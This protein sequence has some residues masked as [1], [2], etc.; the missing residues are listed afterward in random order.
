MLFHLPFKNN[1]D[2][3][4]DRYDPQAEMNLDVQPE[5]EVVVQQEVDQQET[6]SGLKQDQ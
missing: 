3:N 6:A 1:L 5:Q 2:L 4:G